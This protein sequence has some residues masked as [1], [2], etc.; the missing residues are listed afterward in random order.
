MTKYD[1][2][3][4]GLYILY[5]KLIELKA[6]DENEL[7][8]DTQLKPGAID[9]VNVREMERYCLD[10]ELSVIEAP[11]PGNKGTVR[12]ITEKGLGLVGITCSKGDRKVLMISPDKFMD[13]ESFVCRAECMWA[14][15]DV[16][17]MSISSGFKI[18][19]ISSPDLSRLRKLIGAISFCEI[20]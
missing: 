5:R 13:I 8:G 4:T 3:S 17:S 10:F 11:F 14:D 12:D 9:P 7:Y 2:S 6:I 19:E 18:N 1:I 15:Y 20:T 16:N